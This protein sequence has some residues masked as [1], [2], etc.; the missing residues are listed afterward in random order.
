VS[1]GFEDQPEPVC[2]GYEQ[3]WITALARLPAIHTYT[4]IAFFCY[5]GHVWLLMQV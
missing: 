4:T 3:E 2:F 5:F 1:D